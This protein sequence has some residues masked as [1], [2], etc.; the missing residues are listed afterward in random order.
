MPVG[1]SRPVMPRRQSLAIAL[2]LV[3]AGSVLIVAAPPATAQ[4]RCKINAGLV[5]L[6]RVCVYLPQV[7]NPP[8]PTPVPSPT[9]SPARSTFL[10]ACADAREGPLKIDVPGGD[11]EGLHHGDPGSGEGRSLW[12][13]YTAELPE[14]GQRWTYVGLTDIVAHGGNASLALSGIRWVNDSRAGAPIDLDLLKVWSNALGLV[15]APDKERQLVAYRFAFW[16]WVERT[17]DPSDFDSVEMA[18]RDCGGRTADRCEYSIDVDSEFLTLKRFEANRWH[19]VEST[20]T[21]RSFRP[22]VTFGSVA[23]EL[24]TSSFSGS[25][26]SIYI[27]DVEL[28]VCGAEVNRFG[29]P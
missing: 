26:T 28:E 4:T 6:E 15:S 1:S 25:G 19:Y 16:M 5:E 13:F 8:T 24:S 17:S 23:V 22:G 3:L 27:D 9:V 18:L 2:L 12:L 29:Q 21:F 10:K 7:E 11:L 14:T 20:Q